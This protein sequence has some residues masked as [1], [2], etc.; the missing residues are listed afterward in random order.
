MRI[1]AFSCAL[2]AAAAVCVLACCSCSQP[3]LTN[4]V[5][6]GPS[7]TS[8]LQALPTIGEILFDGDSLTAG[9]GATDPY[10]RQVMR[11][12]AGAI[13]W[14]NLGKG[15]RRVE[16]MLKTAG[17]RV[18]PLFDARLGRNVVV[19]WGGSNDLALM[20][21]EPSVVYQ[22]IRNYCLGRERRGFVVLVLTLLPRSD[23]FA[24]NFEVRREAVNQM[25]RTTWSQFASGLVDVAADPLIGPAG[26]ERNRHYYVRGDVHLNNQG[27]AVVAGHVVA[28]LLRLAS[29]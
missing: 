15:G 13:K 26:A 28:G 10:P 6:G 18:D 4:S 17:T 8:V 21:H 20:D 29:Q 1:A 14:K 5:S 9:S 23:R 2:L 3:A 16:D 24:K 25:L 19:V 27:Q 22:N 7:S 11:R 12:M